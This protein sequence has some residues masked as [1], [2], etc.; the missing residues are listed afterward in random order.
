[1]NTKKNSALQT[2]HWILNSRVFRVGPTSLALIPTRPGRCYCYKVGVF[3]NSH[4]IHV[5]STNQIICSG[6]SHGQRLWQQQQQKKKSCEIA[7]YTASTGTKKRGNE[8]ERKANVFLQPHTQPSKRGVRIS[9][10]DEA[11]I[12]RALFSVNTREHHI[13]HK[14]AGRLRAAST[15]RPATEQ[16]A[17]KAGSWGLRATS[18]LKLGASAILHPN[19]QQE[20]DSSVHSLLN[21]QHRSK[22]KGELM[23]K[24]YCYRTVSLWTL[25][26]VPKSSKCGIRFQ[27]S[28]V[29]TTEEMLQQIWKGK[30]AGQIQTRSIFHIFHLHHL[31]V[32][33][34]PE[35]IE[36]PIDGLGPLGGLLS[37]NPEQMRRHWGY[38]HSARKTSA[39]AG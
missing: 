8:N 25:A 37:R 28:Y 38:S 9:L 21:Q 34:S 22:V 1:M 36:G 11:L 32:D 33:S 13:S 29:R 2:P 5:T 15:P 14:A 23:G 30:A 24:R 4:A 35:H 7:K 26:L 6:N 27:S 12:H 18:C 39:D 10:T 17:S 16:L 19:R 31:S 20:P 3:I